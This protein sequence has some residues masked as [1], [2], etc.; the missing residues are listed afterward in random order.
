VVRVT[1]LSIGKAYRQTSDGGLVVENS[2]V[3][4]RLHLAA[5]VCF[6]MASGSRAPGQGAT[7][8]VSVNGS[9]SNPGSQ[10]L[11]F[12]TVQRGVNA[13]SAG[14]TLYITSGTYAEALSSFPGGTSWST[15]VTV[16]ASPGNQVILQPPS[17]SNN[18]LTMASSTIAYVIIDSLILDGTNLSNTST[19]WGNGIYVGGGANHIKVTNT[20]IRNAP[21]AGILT[22]GGVQANQFL[23]NRVHD[24]GRHAQLTHGFYI[25]SSGNTIS[26]NTVYNNA[27]WGIQI[28]GSDNLPSNN[29]ITKNTVYNNT[30]LGNGGGI[31]L[32]SGSAN[33]AYNN[34]IYGNNGGYAV[35][36]SFGGGPSNTRVEN[37]T[38]SNQY[39]IDIGSDASGTL[40]QN[41]IVSGSN[42][43]ISNQGKASTVSSNFVG[44]PLFVNVA[45]ANYHLQ[46]T[47]PAIDAGITI[48]EVSTDFDGITR[49]QGAAYDIGAYEYATLSRPKAPQN[50]HVQ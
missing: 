24:N 33:V 13:L 6:L 41:N 37:N 47:S 9:D 22:A 11:P 25:D 1:N 49:P 42:A 17:G 16:A 38:I 12:R 8:Y 40:V 2:L 10:S 20:E 15:P 4:K 26:G 23:N 43:N 48:A 30:R 44:N 29:L 3:K 28:Y 19:N 31:V 50:V 34:I 39:G 36:I 32:S 27:A 35:E 14:A 46:A 7:Y 21:G 5:L 45:S 18:V